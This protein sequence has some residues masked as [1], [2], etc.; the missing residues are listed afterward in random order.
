MPVGESGIR[1][2]GNVT[3]S[4]TCKSLANGV[5]NVTQIFCNNGRASIRRS[6][7]EVATAAAPPHAFAAFSKPKLFAVRVEKAGANDSC[8][9]EFSIIV[10][11]D[12]LVET[13][14]A[15]AQQGKRYVFLEDR[16]PDA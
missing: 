8:V 2:A 14:C 12:S 9:G 7:H 4:L 5:A 16:R 3:R 10:D 6:P 15:G 13:T 11:L 1:A